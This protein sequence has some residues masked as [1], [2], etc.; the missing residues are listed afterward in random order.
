MTGHCLCKLPHSI[1]PGGTCWCPIPHKQAADPRPY[2]AQLRATVPA[3]APLPAKW[4]AAADLSTMDQITALHRA[5]ADAGVLDYP[6][7]AA[8]A[9]RLIN[10]PLDM[11]SE[12]T[13]SEAATVLAKITGGGT[14]EGDSH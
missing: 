6:G 5:F 12:M 9:G 4:T 11:L 7:R 13:E 2:A 14:N 8:A 3:L 10:R 1:C